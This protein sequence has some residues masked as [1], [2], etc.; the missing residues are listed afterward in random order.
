MEEHPGGKKILVKVA[1][2]DASK[3]FDNFHNQ[4]IMDK[5]GPALFKGDIK[6]AIPSSAPE[7]EEALEGVE[8]VCLVTMSSF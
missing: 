4:S 8:E 5:W 3:Q 1:G 6:G 2:T 7:E